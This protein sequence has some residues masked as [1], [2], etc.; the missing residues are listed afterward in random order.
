M[1]RTALAAVLLWGCALMPSHAQ[2]ARSV[3]GLIVKLKPHSV[4]S[5]QG[6]TPQRRLGRVAAAAGYTILM[7]WRQLGS[8][9]AVMQVPT[10]LKS[11]KAERLMAQAMATGEIEWAQPNVR[12][13]L[14]AVVPNDPMYSNGSNFEDGQWWLKTATSGNGQAQSLRQRGVPSIDVAWMTTTGQNQP[15]GAIIAVLDTGQLAHPDM[16]ASRILPGYDFVS[17]VAFANDGGGRDADPTDPGDWVS[18]S[19]ASQLAFANCDVQSSSWHGMVIQ[20][21]L[22]ARSNNGVGVAGINWNA[23]ILPVRVAGKCGAEVGDIIDGLRWAA[24]LH[25]SGVPDNA[26]PARI[27]NISFGGSGACGPAYQTAINE[28]RAQGAIVVVAAGNE[29]GSVSRPGNCSGVI[30]V[31]SLNREGFKSNY[32]NF[33]PEIAI[34]TIG[35]DPAYSADAGRWAFYLA[36]TGL[37]GLYNSGTT[38]AGSSGYAYHAGTS[39]SAPMVAGVLSLMLDVNPS[40]TLAQLETGLRVTARPHVTSG[41]IGACSNSNPGRCICTTATCGDGI[42]DADQAVIY[43]AAPGSYVP[44][45]VAGENIDSMEVVQAVNYAPTDRD[46]NS[47][48]LTNAPNPSGSGGGGGGGGALD[49]P[50]LLGMGMLSIALLASRFSRAGRRSS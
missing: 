1:I 26:N 15:N 23:R 20:G 37:L 35:G 41:L 43:A 44:L 18:S 39:F 48:T 36:D 3:S 30:A 22:A 49:V 10:P 11:A 17:D 33:G 16:D 7:P 46:A 45:G 29:H 6:S 5:L 13:R 12:E 24:G 50:V 19:E 27:I 8:G 4:T 31:A 42:L 9:M 40:L 25:V 38:T 2:E 21:F 28:V 32:S 34:S 47:V 14:Q